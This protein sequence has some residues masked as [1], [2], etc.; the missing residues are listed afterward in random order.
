MQCFFKEF[1]F[2]AAWVVIT[3]WRFS[4]GTYSL[5]PKPDMKHK[6]VS[7]YLLEVNIIVIW[8]FFLFFP[9]SD[10]RWLKTPKITSK[11]FIFFVLAEVC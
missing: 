6:C 5:N 8:P 7:G 9:F 10:F 2:N 1:F 11:F 3:H 4:L